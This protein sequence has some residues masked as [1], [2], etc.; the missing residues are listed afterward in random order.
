[1]LSTNNK[2]KECVCGGGGGERTTSVMEDVEPEPL[3]ERESWDKKSGTLGGR[4][5]LQ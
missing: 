4:S 2:E 1:M 3:R 5:S